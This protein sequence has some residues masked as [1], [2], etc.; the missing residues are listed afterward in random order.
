MKKILRLYSDFLRYKNIKIT[1]KKIT[2]FLEKQSDIN[3]FDRFF[4]DLYS[5]F[6]IKIIILCSELAN[7]S[8]FKNQNYEKELI[9]IGEGFFRFL[10]FKLIN[11]KIF[12]KK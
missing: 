10:Y 12:W 5:V 9:Y 3:Y 2:V 6:K 8:D 7:V 4:S 11:T 1:E